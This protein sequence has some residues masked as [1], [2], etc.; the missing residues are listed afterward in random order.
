MDED[1]LLITTSLHVVCNWLNWSP[2]FTFSAFIRYSNWGL[3]LSFKGPKVAT[4]RLWGLNRWLCVLW[5]NT[6]TKTPPLLSRG[7]NLLTVSRTRA[8]SVCA[9][10][11]D[12]IWW[13][14]LSLIKD[15]LMYMYVLTFFGG[16]HNQK[17]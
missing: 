11:H 10:C 16:A 5:P 9:V 12:F 1:N 14:T 13:G 6:F 15:L 2:L 3:S 8:I 4:W 7:Q 17:N